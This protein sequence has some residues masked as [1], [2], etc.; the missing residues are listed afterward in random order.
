[1]IGSIGKSG[2]FLYIIFYAGVMSRHFLLGFT[3]AIRR[4]R[5]GL[6]P[7]MTVIAP[8]RNK[9]PPIRDVAAAAAVGGRYSNVSG[10]SH[11]FFVTSFCYLFNNKYIRHLIFITLLRI[12]LRRGAEKTSLVIEQ[13]LPPF[14]YLR[15]PFLYIF[16]SEYTKRRRRRR[17]K[18]RLKNI[19][20]A[21]R[22][23][24]KHALSICR[25][26]YDIDGRVDGASPFHVRRAR[27]ASKIVWFMTV[28]C[29]NSRAVSIYIRAF[30]FCK[31]IVKNLVECFN[32]YK[33]ASAQL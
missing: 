16:S 28:S 3:A 30:Q 11:L 15:F 7:G 18:E 23:A 4:G 29:C 24:E 9:R 25:C 33:C 10:C 1:M 22:W 8:F 2:K 19:K 20:R 14:S 13:W 12:S 5:G 27:W 17:R 21:D 6:R 32:L 31:Y 26:R